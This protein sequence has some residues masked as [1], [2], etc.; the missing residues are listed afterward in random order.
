MRFKNIIN[1]IK[2]ISNPSKIRNIVFEKILSFLY[3]KK[4]G[5]NIFEFSWDYL[6][7]LDACRYDIFKYFFKKS[8]LPGKLSKEFSRGE[9]TISF[10]KE[11]FKESHKDIVYI[12]SNPYVSKYS[13][14]SFYKI[15][16]VWK[17]C[18]DKKE[19][20][21]LPEQMLKVTK[22]TLGKYPSKRFIIHFMQPHYPYIKFDIEKKSQKVSFFNWYSANIYQTIDIKQHKKA[23]IN[24]LKI[25]LN[26][27]KELIDYLSGRIFLT[28]DHGEAFGEWIHP[29]IPIKFYGHRLGVRIPATVEIPLVSINK[30]KRSLGAFNLER[31]KIKLKIEEL[32]NS[33]KI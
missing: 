17:D 14:N 8:N 22:K 4:H 19:K 13:L 32:K 15:I 2:A 24:N 3:P 31:E 25:V 12:S 21:V 7:I 16:P 26:V 28:A 10:L 27:I 5:I 1:S 23:Y 6:I 9:H 33:N 29:L 30:P 20:T 11:N 18:W